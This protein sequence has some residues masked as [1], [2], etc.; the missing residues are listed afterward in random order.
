[1]L[2]KIR[3]GLIIAIVLVALLGHA[4]A[5]VKRNPMNSSQLFEQMKLLAETDAGTEPFG[6]L[7][8]KAG[9][10]RRDRHFTKGDVVYFGQ[11]ARMLWRP[12]V[13]WI[14]WA[15]NGEKFGESTPSIFSVY[16]GQV[17]QKVMDNQKN[18]TLVAFVKDYV[19]VLNMFQ[20]QY[21]V[22]DRHKGPQA[23]K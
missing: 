1:M 2:L 22:L 16:Q 11:G 17:S 15:K 14:L 7:L 3:F 12:G 18:P 20:N 9:F 23:W 6:K 4:S 8:S 5:K 19:I 10:K 13:D 21:S